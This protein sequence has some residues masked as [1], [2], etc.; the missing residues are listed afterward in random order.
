MNTR[1]TIL[2]KRSCFFSGLPFRP[3]VPFYILR[4][5]YFR[6]FY[7][8]SIRD[9]IHRYLSEWQH[10]R[11]NSSWWYHAVTCGGTEIVEDPCWP[12]GKSSNI[13]LEEFLECPPNPANNRQTRM[14]ADLILSACYNQSNPTMSRAQIEEFQ[15]Q[16][17]K[18]NLAQMY[19][20]MW[21]YPK[22]SQYIFEKTFKIPF[23]I[24]F[25]V[26]RPK[27]LRYID[28]I[29]PQELEKIKLR[30]QY[31]IELY[32]FGEKLFLKRFNLTKLENDDFEGINETINGTNKEYPW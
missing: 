24:P 9:P 14:L 17:A 11:R 27:S 29:T 20:F 30:N 1:V 32:N 2:R 18:K 13:T 19:F 31:D 23:S 12:R 21:K 7:L 22:K 5:V 16:S 15:L 28:K 4:M 6:Y 3:L 8:T 25:P 10:V 26:F